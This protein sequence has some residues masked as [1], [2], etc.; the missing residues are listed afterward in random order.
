MTL[1]AGTGSKLAAIVRTLS[2]QPADLL[3]G[4]FAQLLFQE[5]DTAELDA[6]ET[7]DLA[8]L[9]AAVGSTASPTTNVSFLP[10]TPPRSLIMSRM[11]S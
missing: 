3:A 10:M 11:I 6:Y 8:S 1:A 9:A 5:A 2:S 7:G 4:R